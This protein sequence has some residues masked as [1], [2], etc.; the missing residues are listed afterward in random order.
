MDIDAIFL[1]ESEFSFAE[2][3][4]KTE[5]IDDI[6][7]KIPGIA[8]QCRDG[9]IKCTER[10][11]IEDID[12]IPTPA[13][14]LIDLDRYKSRFNRI[15]FHLV[16]SRGCPFKCTF[17]SL[18]AISGGR[19]RTHS[20]NRVLEELEIIKSFKKNGRLMFHDDFFAINTERT[21]HLCK[22]MIKR[23]INLKWV[24]RSRVDTVDL[25]T[26]KLMKESG[27]EEIFME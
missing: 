19:Y 27:C 12:V 17:C 20:V 3:V 18:P 14:H 22:G 1:G 16:T 8:F 2:Y 25:D 21:R 13:F 4:I 5:S 9:E 24:T 11:W 7:N 15:D 23:K 10:K 26:L 6:R